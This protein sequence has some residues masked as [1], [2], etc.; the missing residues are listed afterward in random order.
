MEPPPP[1]TR[2]FTLFEVSWEIC[3]K[4][5]GIHT[6][7][8][9]K[10]KTLVERFGDE[11]IA[12]GPWLLAERDLPFEEEPGLQGFAES[13]RALGLP[14]RIGRWRI[15]GR[16]RTILVEFSRLYEQKDTVLKQLWEDFKVDS[17]S[18]TWDYIEPVLFGYAAGKVIE[19]WWEEH[20]ATH[21]RRAVVNVHEWMTAS[22]L[23]YLRRKVP[24]I[25][26]VFTTHA[27]VLG[28]TLSSLGQSPD[29]GLGEQTPAD[30]AVQHKVV[31]KH[32]IESVGAREAD[33]LTTVSEITAKEATVLLGRTPQPITPNGL[34]LAVID[35]M[36]GKTARDQA[37]TT[38]IHTASRFF[39]ED[40]SDAAFLAISGR[41][42]FH[43]KGIDLL[44]DAL[45]KLDK[46]S[47][48]RV[49]LFILVP[50]GNSGVKG[51]FLER[52][53][54]SLDEL[55]GPLGLSTHNLFDAEHDPVQEHC[56]RLGLANAPDSRIRIIHVP[57]YL[58]EKDG[59]WNLPY[60]AVLRA[61]DLS[62]FPSYYEPWGYTPQESLAVGVPTV[63][64]DYA[65]F[66]RWALEAKLG[67]ENGVTVLARVHVQY[68]HVL[69][70]L[71]SSIERFLAEGKGAKEL[72]GICRETAK[73]TTWTHFFDR[74]DAAYTSALIA[75]Q[76]RL[77]SGVQQTRRPKQTLAVQPAPEGRRP[78]L[79]AFDV[80]STLPEPLEGLGRLSRNLCWSWDPDGPTLFEEISPRA[81]QASGHNPV[82]F[83]QRAYPE[84]L[85]AKADDPAY[86]RRLERAL[87]RLDAYMEA[88]F[89]PASWPGP[90]GGA[91]PI[92][93]AHPIA[94]FCAE[95]GIHESLRIYSG[96]LG[97]LAGDHLKS[98][99]DLGLP[100]IAVGLF[101]RM[102]YVTQ[103][104]SPSGEQI[105]IDVENDPRQLPFEAVRDENGNALEIVLQLPGRKL[106]LRA[107]RVRVG[108][109]QL[110]L[111][112]SYTPSNRPEDQDITR[113]L[114]GGNE[115]TRLL[116]EIVLGRGGAQL[117]SRL[118]IQPSVYHMNEGHPAFLALERVG[119]LAHK[120]GLTFEEAREFVRATTLFTTHT[121]VP[122]GHDRFS[123]DL[124]R[125][126]FSDAPDWVGVPWERFYALGQAEGDRSAFNMTYL[127]L[128]FSSF[129][130]GVSALHGMA[131]RKLLRPFWPGLL[132]SEVPVTSITNGIHLPSWTH[133][134]ISRSLDAVDRK[135][136]PEDFA[137]AHSN[138]TLN[139]FWNA[140]RELRRRLLEKIRAR[141]SRVFLE[142]GDQPLLLNKML[143]GLEENALLVGFARRFAPYKRAALLFQDPERLRALL[144]DQDRPVRIFFAGKAHPNDGLGKELVKSIAERTRRDEFAGKVFF[145]EDYDARL[146][147]ALV[148]GVDV[149]LNNPIRMLEASGTSGMKAAA[150]G[151]LNV[152]IGDGW[153]PEALQ[154]EAG[155]ENG[156]LIGGPAVYQDPEL[157]NQFD[158][159]ALY[160][161]L[162]EEIV[163]TFFERDRNDV[164][165]KWIERV[166]RSLQTVPS[167]FN[168]DRMVKEYY[169][170][171][172][173]NLAT[174]FQE[175]LRNKK[176][177][178]KML[179][180][181]N[182]R[183]RKGFSEI[184]IV[185]VQVGELKDLHV[186]DPVE[187]RAEVNL[188]SLKPD[189]VQVE[190][191]VGH[192]NGDS[193]L[194]GRTAVPLI[195]VHAGPSSEHVFEGACPMESSGNFA[196]G[197]RVRARTEREYCDSLRDLVLWA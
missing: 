40:V 144:D 179:V 140:K 6:V 22:A 142:R 191:V 34:D 99:S 133:T 73:R 4:V 49:V 125:R 134:E 41:Y 104:I 148:Q 193:D 93:A 167:Q 195:H 7:I 184:R 8:S 38:L 171:A 78:H 160:R 15:P 64:S 24:S 84:D 152:S 135:I 1:V 106:N 83:L 100:L 67:P 109:V 87:E 51:E 92:S 63:T 86:V 162:E 185:S 180:Q 30:V 3:N 28:R 32:S 159:N 147:R 98:A 124:M 16:P 114:Y 25:G 188:G 52:K 154:T 5:G 146:A 10:A 90:G 112:D 76:G 70:N 61:M 79:F 37:R 82:S 156:W 194:Q 14:V 141:L 85:Q 178:L 75:V 35:E 131:S 50:A 107:W 136:Q 46:R 66:G 128:Q 183:V 161:L 55:E 143:D 166:S 62:L 23:L 115:E 19:R 153:W 108:R 175:L 176:W 68:E 123:E 94:Y 196:Y 121:P 182:Q 97:I 103:Q 157:Q 168:T 69:E 27:T 127:A 170:R 29:D 72:E 155:S 181:E 81:W 102:G 110:Y 59:F 122:A 139:A 2:P 113:N 45:A 189:D 20:L 137:I 174:G 31:A 138:R 120:E 119:Q 57:I 190:L 91:S 129:C 116:Q 11:Y 43:N 18:G 96:G 169:E 26:T 192:S 105:S 53:D 130:N 54:R 197:V 126:Y 95:Y 44:L 172:Y 9:T 65:G 36:A 164:P 145:L 187:V 165:R 89:E 101:Y 117:L 13:C 42:E 186:G 60:L 21:H 111:L 80:S 74:Y 56:A 173:A 12:I 33:V 163:P 132:E 39:G 88:A 17:I 150:N 177:K 71:C 118:S 151:T 47:G 149:W 77:E 58:G 158:A 48:R